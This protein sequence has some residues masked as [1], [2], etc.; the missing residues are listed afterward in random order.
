MYVPFR[1]ITC[2]F[3][4]HKLDLCVLENSSPGAP[5]ACHRGEFGRNGNERDSCVGAVVGLLGGGNSVVQV[6]TSL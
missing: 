3:P 6:S 4:D 1:E 2:Y 5:N